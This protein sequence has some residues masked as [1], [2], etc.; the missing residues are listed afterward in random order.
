MTV[1]Q[2]VIDVLLRLL[3][4]F[5]P[6]FSESL[7]QELK[8]KERAE[9]DMCTLMK[10]EWPT[11]ERLA[12][13]GLKEEEDSAFEVIDKMMLMVDGIR[14]LKG[15]KRAGATVIVPPKGEVR[16]FVRS[17]WPGVQ[18][19]SKMKGLTLAAADENDV[20]QWVR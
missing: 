19:L 20:E 9:V 3:H 13:G 7:W 17:V 1:L 4:P 11:K 10:A 8:P 14:T 5:M 18:R 15:A 2:E 16:E 6:H 12:L